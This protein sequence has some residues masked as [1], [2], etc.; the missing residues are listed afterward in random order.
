MRAS[1]YE[2]YRKEC[3]KNRNCTTCYCE[4][5]NICFAKLLEEKVT[6]FPN[7][8]FSKLNTLEQKR[9]LRTKA[10]PLRDYVDLIVK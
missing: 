9:V 8:E 1:T 4:K 10:Y 2:I 6:D 7:I 3:K 5:K